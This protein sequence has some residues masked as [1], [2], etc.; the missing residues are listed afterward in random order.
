MLLNFLF[1][2]W[3]WFS[4]SGSFPLVWMCEAVECQDGSLTSLTKSRLIRMQVDSHG[5]MLQGRLAG[6]GD[7][8]L[9]PTPSLR[10]SDSASC[11]LAVLLSPHHITVSAAPE[12]PPYL[13]HPGGK[14]E[15]ELC[16]GGRGGERGGL[17]RDQAQEWPP[18]L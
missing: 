5:A 9:C 14:P 3:G 8:G 11:C 15:Q 16:T 6:G 1:F 10:D 4:N 13:L 18:S 2:F 12:S 7:G 17:V